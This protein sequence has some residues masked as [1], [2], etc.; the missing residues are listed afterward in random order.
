[1]TRL[2]KKKKKRKTDDGKPKKRLFSS[3]NKKLRNNEYSKT[4]GLLMG[5]CLVGQ[6]I[7]IRFC[8]FIKKKIDFIKSV[9]KLNNST[10]R[11]P[12]KNTE[13]KENRYYHSD[14]HFFSK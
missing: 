8:S 9:H 4:T 1:M 6:F 12:F 13:R 7:D 3:E 5:N 2:Q 10:H 14:Y 11:D